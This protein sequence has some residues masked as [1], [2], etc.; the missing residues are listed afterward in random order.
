MLAA[1]LVGIPARAY[2]FGGSNPHPRIQGYIVPTS[3]EV[4]AL[5]KRLREGV[6][7]L[8]ELRDTSEEETNS[9]LFHLGLTRAGGLAR[10]GL[11]GAVTTATAHPHRH[12]HANR[13][14]THT[15]H[16]QHRRSTSDP[17]RGSVAYKA[18]QQQHKAEKAIRW[19][20]HIKPAAPELYPRP[21]F[22]LLRGCSMSSATT[23]LL[24]PL[25]AAHGIRLMT[26]KKMYNGDT[27]ASK[28]NASGALLPYNGSTS[29]SK[30]N[31]SGAV[32]QGYDWELKPHKNPCLCTQGT[33]PCP[34]HERTLSHAL[35][36]MV[37]QL[38]AY[39]GGTR[40]V[41]KSGWN[42]LAT[43]DFVKEFRPKI[44]L[45]YRSNFLDY[46]ACRIRDCFDTAFVSG[47]TVFANG[48]S[49]ADLCFDRRKKDAPVT[50]A[51][52]NNVEG[53]YTKLDK[54]TQY[55]HTSLKAW[56]KRLG[57]PVQHM[58]T[59]SL[60]AF[61][62]SNSVAV[63]NGSL[64]AWAR[65]ISEL[66][67]VPNMSAITAYLAPLVATRP[68]PRPHSATIYNHRALLRIIRK[69]KRTE[70]RDG[71]RHSS[72]QTTTKAST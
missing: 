1:A 5:E 39:Q 17:K 18:K 66:G 13:T 67:V 69:S 45:L 20:C 8:K 54:E 60:L 33:W 31:A 23:N 22:V 46:Q 65:L 49:A 19:P 62:T 50:M 71:W 9:R 24:A 61:E 59:E 64:H 58:S 56:S 53:I 55:M 36:R 42:D 32:L 48:S 27:P 14:H 68:A 21:L 4:E 44:V 40:L 30:D 6:Q 26:R 16:M 25:L 51:K 37:A 34:K 70:L 47:H 15:N 38:A 2:R 7:R 10:T 52:F 3:L 63:F 43:V 12:G 35:S 41:G 11:T 28:G 29:A 72:P 57:A